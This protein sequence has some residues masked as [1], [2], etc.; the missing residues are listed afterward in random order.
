MFM[1]L[2]SEPARACTFSANTI[3]SNRFNLKAGAKICLVCSM[4][5]MITPGVI[6]ERIAIDALSP[7]RTLPLF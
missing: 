3:T 6:E 7:P 5:G 2:S 1:I 4:R